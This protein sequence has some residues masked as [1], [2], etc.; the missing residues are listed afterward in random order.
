MTRYFSE[1]NLLRLTEASLILA[2]GA[3]L[4]LWLARIYNAI[5]FVRPSM[6]VTTGWEGEILF[7]IWKLVQ[8]QAV[9]ADPHRIPFAA[10]LY[11]WG[12]YY[13]YGLVSEACLRLFHLDA[14]WIATVGR[15]VTV[16]FTLVTGWIF[17]LAQKHLVKAG[18]FANPRISWAWCAIAACS[19]LVGFA[20]ISVRPDL[21]ALAFEC[22][23]LY[24]ILRYV[25]KPS[26]RLLLG[27]ALLFY[28]AWAFK[29]SQVTMLAGS[30]L[31]LLLLRRWRA[32]L[33]LSGIWWLLV[34]ATLILGGP[35]YRESLLF[36][37]GHLPLLLKWGLLMARRAGLLN[38]FLPLSTAAILGIT[39]RRT[40][41]AALT[42]TETVV[43]AVL[44]FS[45]CFALITACNIGSAQNYYIP[46]AWV[47][48]LGLTLKSEQVNSRW[49]LAG[50]V[51]CSLL[52]AAGAVRAQRELGDYRR[53]DSAHRAVAEKL[54][55]L[56]GP[57]FV[58][59]EYSNLPWVQR[60]SPYFALGYIYDQDRTAH[61]RFEDDGWQGLAREGYFGSIVLASPLN[62]RPPVFGFDFYSIYNLPPNL[63]QNY[64]LAD[65][66]SDG[67]VVYKFYR[68]LEVRTS[69]DLVR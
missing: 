48:M 55:H 11:N 29:Q 9:Y 64:E 33:T 46:A 52:M 39:W 42:P 12:F 6:S 44:L 4:A 69:S 35:T 22:A 65:E 38:L 18:L 58:T 13:F 26:V 25:S 40:R 45:I 20:S 50:L 32:L 28:I 2:A 24:T 57:A 60:Y 43:T 5:S 41:S 30:V 1:R 68:R 53:Q 31:A 63:L 17:F 47:A 66:F 21:G 49:I 3:C 36:S 19:P 61:V 54:S 15:I 7:S 62:P 37:R 14:E 10:S 27:A 8:H 59:E 67:Y 51:V 56:P 16:A 34:I 23:G